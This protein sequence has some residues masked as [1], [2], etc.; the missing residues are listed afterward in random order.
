MH[1]FITETKVKK[2]D[3]TYFVFY[4]YKCNCVILFLSLSTKQLDLEKII[5]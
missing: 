4:I 5:L 1:D 2:T 3:F